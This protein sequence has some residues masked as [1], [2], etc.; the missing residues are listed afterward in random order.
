[1]ALTPPRYKGPPLNALRAFE[2]AARLGGFSAAA[3]ELNVTAGAIAQHIKSVE[4]WAGAKLFERKAQG[5]HLTDFGR[6]IV[7]DFTVAFDRVGD[8]VQALREKAT[9]KSLR[10]A[11]LPAVAQMWLSP[12]LQKIRDILG[13]ETVSV[14]AMERR[15]NLKRE[16]YDM[17]FFYEENSEKGPLFQ[18][19]EDTIFPVCAPA[20]ARNIGSAHDLKGQNLLHD[21]GWRADWQIWFEKAAPDVRCAIQGPTFSLYDIAIKE[22]V[23]AAGILIGH[24]TLVRPYIESGELVAPVS[25][26]VRLDRSLMMDASKT[27]QNASVF[28]E[29]LLALRATG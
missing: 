6:S 3:D 18:L 17:S 5:V 27:I 16:P 12:R 28:S 9:T 22:A 21:A 20:L 13:V 24:E 23:S 25:K 29:L 1:M 11:A 10:I 7:D 4:A 8:A 15:P 26:K 2:A 19:E 14:S